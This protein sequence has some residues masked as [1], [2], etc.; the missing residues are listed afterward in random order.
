MSARERNLELLQ[1]GLGAFSR[2][3]FDEAMAH[4]HP[5]IEWHVTFALPDRPLAKDVYRG[6][7]EVRE[8][9]GV[10]ASVWEQLTTELEEVLYADDERIVARARF[11]GRGAGSGVEVD[12]LVFYSLRMRDGLLAYVRAFDDEASARR[13][14]GLDDDD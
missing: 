11:R 9:W 2:G 14:L 13:D 6:R 7:D 8:L 5:E 4:M 3:A 1:Q 12:R 10:F